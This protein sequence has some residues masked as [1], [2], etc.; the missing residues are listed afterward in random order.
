VGVWYESQ[1]LSNSG[2]AK[3]CGALQESVQ[4]VSI[5]ERWCRENQLLAESGGCCEKITYSNVAQSI[6]DP[7]DLC[8]GG[9]VPASKQGTLVSTFL[10][11]WDCG[12][13]SFAMQKGV[14]SA[15]NCPKI[16]A[17]AGDE[18]CSAITARSA[19]NFLRGADKGIP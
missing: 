2:T 12:G 5:E 11:T 16:K 7:C 18:C 17:A 10:G 1:S 4:D 6:N 13:L 9:S 14:L 15:N 19:T 3:T 8:S